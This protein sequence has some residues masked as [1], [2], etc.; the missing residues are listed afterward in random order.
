MRKSVLATAAAAGALAAAVVSPSVSSAVPTTVT[1]TVNGGPL[2][3]TAPQNQ[4]LTV[5]GNTASGDITPVTVSDQR[6]GINGWTATAVS[7]A[8][9]KPAPDPSS[10]PATAV[11][12]SAPLLPDR[13]G[14]S[15]VA[16]IV[17]PQ[18]IDTT[19]NVVAATAVLGRNTATW[20]GTVTVSLPGEVLAG[21][22]TGVVTHSVA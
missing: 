6:A 11:T 17:V 1:F 4:P 2:T 12:Y 22:Y 15:T 13:T 19:K 3:I 7:T 5:T 8:F 16:G 18:V 14:V 10:I 20:A 9:T 21:T